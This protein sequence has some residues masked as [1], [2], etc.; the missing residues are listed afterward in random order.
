MLE[1][2][3]VVPAG[4]ENVLTRFS[5]VFGLEKDVFEDEGL[6]VGMMGALD[7]LGT[8]GTGTGTGTAVSECPIGRC[9]AL[10]CGVACTKDPGILGKLPR[11]EECGRDEDCANGLGVVLHRGR[12]SSRS[13]S[14]ATASSNE[15][16]CDNSHISL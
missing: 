7:M 6:E 10:D 15:S 16:D 1:D 4:D 3:V 14:R 5:E 2:G 12:C 11:C 9:I 13:N 8:V